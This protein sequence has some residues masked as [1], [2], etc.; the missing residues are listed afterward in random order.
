[1]TGVLALAQEVPAN[2]AAYAPYA[3]FFLGGILLLAFG[4]IVGRAIF[5]TRRDHGNVLDINA[6][7]RAQAS[8][9]SEGRRAA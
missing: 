9:R 3:A 8:A 5:G 2:Y 4:L 1:M 7:A 6:A